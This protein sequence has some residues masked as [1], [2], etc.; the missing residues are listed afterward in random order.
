MA[1]IASPSATA[2][3]RKSL[4]AEIVG[5]RLPNYRIVVDRQKHA[6]SPSVRAGLHLDDGLTARHRRSLAKLAR[7]GHR[8][9]LGSGQNRARQQS[10]QYASQRRPE[11]RSGVL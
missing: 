8:C 4:L 6:P 1:L 9:D 3:M 2:V 5:N 7:V 11:L 10:T